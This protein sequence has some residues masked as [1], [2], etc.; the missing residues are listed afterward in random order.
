MARPPPAQV[1]AQAAKAQ[2]IVVLGCP[3]S[4]RLRRRLDR[5]IDLFQQGLAPALVLSG[6]GSGAT[7]EAEIMRRA[8]TAYGIPESALLVEP[9]S[10]DTIGNARETARLLRHPGGRALGRQ[11]VIGAARTHNRAAGSAGISAEPGARP[12]Y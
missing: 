11:L 1:K 4:S 3:S 5:G 8:A 10:R 2:A 12:R 9:Y 7:P 6:G